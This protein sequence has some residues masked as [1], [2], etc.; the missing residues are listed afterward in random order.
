MHQNIFQKTECERSPDNPKRWRNCISCSRWL[1][2]IIKEKL[3]IPRTHSETGIHRKERK[4]RNGEPQ[5]DREE[6]QPKETKDDAE[7]QKDFWSHS[8]IEFIYCHHTEPRSST[9]VPREESIRISKIFNIERN[10][11]EK[12]FSMRWEDWRKAKTSEAKTNSIVLMLQERTEFCTLLQLYAR[13][14]S[15]KRSQESSSLNFLWRWKQAHVVSSRG[16]AY[17]WDKQFFK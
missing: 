1:S 14:R 10:S 3:R 5:G 13:I 9:Y 2:K 12:T 8:G 16:A 7:A 15:L 11:S 4:N 6:F 17:L